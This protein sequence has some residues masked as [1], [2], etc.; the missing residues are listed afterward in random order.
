MPINEYFPQLDTTAVAQEIAQ[1]D[2]DELEAE[3]EKAFKAVTRL[4]LAVGLLPHGVTPDEIQINA[5]GWSANVRGLKLTIDQEHFIDQGEFA[6]F[7]NKPCHNP[8]C[9]NHNQTYTPF[10]GFDKSYGEPLCWYCR[11]RG[12]A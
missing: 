9:E 11:K 8:D 3:Y 7:V 4:G 10:K 2:H 6:I 5:T 12:V 1:D